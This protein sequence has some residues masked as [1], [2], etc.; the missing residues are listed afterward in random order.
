MS[1]FSLPS[2]CHM[3]HVTCHRSHGTL[4]MAHGTCH[5]S[6]VPCHMSHI[7]CHMSHVTWHMAHGTWHMS[8]VTS[9]MSHVTCRMSNEEKNWGGV[10]GQGVEL[11]GGGSFINMTYPVYFYL[12]YKQIKLNYILCNWIILF[13][14]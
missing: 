2:M 5:K 13:N 11:I 9:H 8:H 4:H 6:Q 12:M 14:I 3:S 1:K 7:T 10:G